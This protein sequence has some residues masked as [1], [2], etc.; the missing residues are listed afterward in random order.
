M[1][2]VSRTGSIEPRMNQEGN[3]GVGKCDGAWSVGCGSVRP[4]WLWI[5]AACEAWNTKVISGAGKAEDLATS[6]P[7][8]STQLPSLST[9]AGFGADSPR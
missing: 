4:Y 8:G 5:A 7:G 1:G 3:F 2:T 6:G 9:A